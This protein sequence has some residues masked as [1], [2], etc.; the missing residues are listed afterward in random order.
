[1]RDSLDDAREADPY[2]PSLSGRYPAWVSQPFLNRARRVRQAITAPLPGRLSRRLFHIRT[3]LT[4]MPVEQKWRPVEGPSFDPD[5]SAY[6]VLQ[7]REGPGDGT[8]PAW[9]ARL[10]STPLRQVYDLARADKHSEL[11]E[12]RETLEVVESLITH[13]RLPRTTASRDERIGV[14]KASRSRMDATISRVRAG[15]LPRNDPAASDQAL[16]R[17]FIE[18]GSLC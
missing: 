16:W 1:M 3:C 6:P 13:G 18:E 7:T 14:A 15:Q 11:L 12:H 10:A 2:D 9:S 4:P 5:R 8:V 17:R